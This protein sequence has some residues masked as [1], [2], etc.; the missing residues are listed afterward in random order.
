MGR[1]SGGVINITGGTSAKVNV[2]TTAIL[3]LGSG[4]NTSSRLHSAKL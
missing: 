3:L 4:T 1:N 2:V